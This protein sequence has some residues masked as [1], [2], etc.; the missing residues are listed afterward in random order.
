MVCASRSALQGASRAPDGD[1]RSAPIPSISSHSRPTFKS[2]PPPAA[3]LAGS[4]VGETRQASSES[5]APSK[6]AGDCRTPRRWRAPEARAKRLGVRWPSTAL[7]GAPKSSAFSSRCKPSFKLVPSP[8]ACLAGSFMGE[9]CE[10]GQSGTGVPPVGCALPD[11]GE[12][13]VSLSLCKPSFKLA[14]MG[15]AH[16]HSI[17]T[18]IMSCPLAQRGP[19]MN[20]GHLRAS[21]ACVCTR[22][23]FS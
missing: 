2:V 13:P 11:T 20:M 7:D 5:D 4:F 15:A 16:G 22:T 12:T 14:I 10:N 9:T 1:A 19:R 8:A 21:L 23:R 17:S 6:A 18:T 3:C